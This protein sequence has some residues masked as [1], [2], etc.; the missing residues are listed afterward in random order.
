MPAIETRNL[1]TPL[2]LEPGDRLTRA[3]F[4]RRYDAMPNVKKAELIEGVVYMPSPVRIRRH[5]DPHYR[6]ICWLG[7][8]STYTPFLI[9][10]DNATARLDLNNEP[11]PDAML[12]IDPELGGQAKI[13]L[14]DY[15]EF[16]PE[17]VGEISGSSASFDLHTK[18]IVYRRNGVREYFVWRV[19]D[20]QI[21]WFT[22]HDGEFVLLQPDADGVLKSRV[23]PGL[24]LDAAAMLRGD[25]PRVLDVVRLGLAS[26]EHAAFLSKYK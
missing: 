16:A 24:W 8:Y 26:P 12:L 11:Q 20:Q 7:H 23:F 2:P 6:T 9:G 19:L 18:L 1:N 4:E 14:D 17:W 25:M 21:D 3:E 15:V 10:A 13:S 22:L 5:G